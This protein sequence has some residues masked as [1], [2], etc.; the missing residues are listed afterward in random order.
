[1]RRALRGLASVLG[2]VAAVAGLPTLL[3]ALVGWPLPHGLPAGSEIRSALGEGWRPGERFVLGVLAVVLWVLWAQ[4]LRHLAA[5]IRLCRRAG[6]GWPLVATATPPG[7]SPTRRLA[8]WLVSGVMLAGPLTT[9]ATA[10]TPAI[11]VMLYT[12]R[13]LDVPSATAP[14]TA[15]VPAATAPAQVAVASPEPSYVVRTWEERRDCLWTIAGRFMGDP[16]RWGELLD[17]NADVRQP[18]GRR[19]ADDPRHWVYPGMQLRLPAGARIPDEAIVRRGD[20]LWSITE[21]RLEAEQGGRPAGAAVRDAVAQ[22]IEL[23]RDRLAD[24]ADP[25]LLFAGQVLRLAPKQAPEARPEPAGADEVAPSVA[26]PPPPPAP[27]DAGSVPARSPAAAVPATGA[28]AAPRPAVDG[29]TA[30]SAE[31]GDHGRAVGALGT[32]GTM[33]AVGVAAAL[34]RRRRRRRAGLPRR[35][36]EPPPPPELDGLRAELYLRADEDH[37]GRLHRALRDVARAL[38]AAGSDARPRLVQVSPGRV[39]VVLS[40]PVVPPPPGWR[41]Q[42]SGTAWT[43][44]GEPADTDTDGPAPAPALVSI[45]RPDPGTELYLDLEAE[46]VVCLTGDPDRVADVARSWILELATSPLAA[47][48]S[49]LLA[50][51]TLAAPGEDCRVRAV[52]S[53]E[54]AAG[55]VGTWIDQSAALLGAHRWPTPLVGRLGAHDDGLAPLVVFAEP[56]EGPGLAEACRRVLDAAVTVTVVV[57]GAEVPGATTVR[58]EGAGLA[59]ESLGLSCE[60]QA[61]AE[62]AAG[63]IEALLD[64]AS[65]VPCQLSFLPEPVPAP[66]LRVG[67]DGDEYRDPP[68]EVLVRLLGEIEVVGGRQRLRPQQV[69]VVA[70]IALHAPVASDQICDAVWASETASRRRRLANT[71]SNCRKALGPGHL[72]LA[73]AEGRYRVG[74]GVVTDAELF[75]RRVAFAAGQGPAAARATLRGA[76]E[77]VTGPVFTTRQAERSSFVWVDLEQWM[78]DWELRVT[79]AA[80]DLA[81]RCLDLGDTEGAVWAARRGLEAC[82]THTRLTKL[83]MEAHLANGDAEAARR[84]CESHQAALEKLELD[85]LGA[86]LVEIYQAARGERA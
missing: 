11:P 57:V 71:A 61:L 51:P 45:G 70:Y 12:T 2:L 42:A 79:E 86:D 17:L 76:L 37:A 53:W 33:V 38:A 78:S 8:G 46:G 59:I 84:V 72:P 65:H 66:P 64:D 18:D 81:E 13:V 74:P 69:A 16:L 73:D 10:A 48:V 23:N 50:G 40:R 52:A 36:A 80:E 47:G 5:E 6:T 34:A 77:L 3:V 7:R 83:L 39:E 26:A 63:Q 24:P 15:P 41:A 14:A 56:G 67:A 30:V 44:A 28:P 75:R 32:A 58:V 21:R 22:V 29:P 43:L 85:D 31:D 35:A 1:V 54:E 55:D 62:E 60:A 20:S 4:L 25:D 9:A 19:L 68:F 82:R 27:P 49:V